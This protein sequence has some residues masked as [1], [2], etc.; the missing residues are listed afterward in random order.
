MPVDFRNVRLGRRTHDPARVATVQSH[1]MGAAAKVPD[2]LDRSAIP[3]TPHDCGNKLFPMCTGEATL[4]CAAAWSWVQTG[5]DI[6]FDPAKIQAFYA[7][8]VGVPDTP[9]AISATDGAV[10]LDVLERAERLGFDVGQQVPL[11]PVYESIDTENQQAIAH[12]VLECGAADIGVML[13]VSD[14]YMSVWD[15]NTPAVAG[16][17]APGSWGGHDTFIFDWDGMEPT[18]LVRIGT[19]AAWQRATWRW[20][21]ARLQAQE[22]FAL[23]WPQIARVAA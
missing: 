22:A 2:K 14:Q 12:A 6:T 13:S 8:C 3:F 4:N 17:P 16:D 18:S 7:A 10:I 9:A 1:R 21:M 23:R 15:T 5:A 19:W 11:V 20:V